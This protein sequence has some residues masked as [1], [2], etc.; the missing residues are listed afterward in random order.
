MGRT[1]HGTVDG[2]C[3]IPVLDRFHG[4]LVVGSA[5]IFYN[6]GSPI[7]IRIG[8]A[9]GAA[10]RGMSD[11]QIRELGRW[12]SDAFKTTFVVTSCS[13]SW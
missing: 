10:L 11:S 13:S 4:L 12:K 7:L 5:W 3:R 8:A 9:T 2:K 6:Q 1:A